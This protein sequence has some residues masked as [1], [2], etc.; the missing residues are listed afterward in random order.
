MADFDFNAYFARRQQ[1]AGIG[2]DSKQVSVAEAMQR[3]LQGLKD[4]QAQV[5]ANTQQIHALK[6]AQANSV[7]GQLGLDRDGVAADAVN[8]AASL[9][10]GASR[11]AGQVV[12]AAPNAIAALQTLGLDQEDLDAY[13]RMQQG[14]ASEQDMARLNTRRR[15]FAGAERPAPLEIIKT[16]EHLRRGTS[17]ISEAF[18][19][20]GIVDP[21]KRAGLTE[22]LDKQAINQAFDRTKAGFQAGDVGEMASGVG[23][24]LGNA[25]KA[26]VNNKGAALEYIVENAPQL[27]AA[28]A[29]PGAM[30]T[31]NAAYALDEFTKGIVRYTN[32]NNGQLPSEQHLREMGVAAVSLAAAEQLGDVATLGLGKAGKLLGRGVKEGSE[33]VVKTAATQGFKDTLK[34]V[35]AGTAKYAGA[36]AGS[37]ANEALTEGY[38]TAVE[39]FLQ[40][41]NPTAGDV[42]EGA[43]I[44]AL[45]GGGTTAVL[46]GAADL[47][48]PSAAKV[49]E[50]KTEDRTQGRVD[51]AIASGDVSTLADSSKPTYAPDRAIAALIEINKK[52]GITPEQ[53]SANQ[54]QAA[55]ILSALQEKVTEVTEHRQSLL[56]EGDTE[57]A[58]RF[59]ALQIKRESQLKAAEEA[60][61]A[62]QTTSLPEMKVEDAVTALEAAPADPADAEAV[63]AQRRAAEA[64][65]TLAM[66][67]NGGLDPQVAKRLA[68]NTGN[69]LTAQQ[70]NY[71]RRFSDA[72]IAE[73]KA[74]GA[75][76]VKSEVLDGSDKNIGI[77]QYRTRI[78]AA[79]A[80]GNKAVVEKNLAM[81]GNFVRDHLGKAQEGQKALEEAKRLDRDVLLLSD[82]KRG[83]SVET[84]STLTKAEVTA[85]GGLAINPIRSKGLIAQIGL[86][87]AALQAA[88]AELKA[89]ADLKFSTG[90][91]QDV[92]NSAQQG[93]GAQ[94][95][96]EAAAVQAGGQAGAGNEPGNPGAVAAAGEPEA[97]QSRGVEST[98]AQDNSTARASGSAVGRSQVQSTQDES[99]SNPST[100]EPTDQRREPPVVDSS[101]V[102]SSPKVAEEVDSPVEEAALAPETPQASLNQSGTLQVNQDKAPEGTGFQSKRFGDFF[103]Q[104][105]GN[106]DKGTVRPLVAVKDFLNALAQDINAALPFLKSDKLSDAQ[107]VVLR[108]FLSVSR[109]WY[110]AI[111]SGLIRSQN[112]EY[113]FKDPMQFLLQTEEG[114]PALELNVYAAIN[115]AAFSW[116]SENATRP[117]LNSNA[118]INKIFGRNE[119]A[120][121]PPSV[122]KQMTRAGSRRNLVLNT[123]GQRA[124][125]ALGIK[126]LQGVPQERLPT[127]SLALGAQVMDLLIAQGYMQQTTFSGAEM[128]EMLTAMK[129][130]K[131]ADLKAEYPFVSLARTASNELPIKT[132]EIWEAN[133]GTQGL[134]DKLF[135]VELDSQPP[136]DKPIPFTIKKLKNSLRSVPKTLA[137]ILAKEN[138]VPYQIR[139][140]MWRLADQM[141]REIMLEI[142]GAEPI[143]GKHEINQSS[144]QAKNDALERELAVFLDYAAGL[145]DPKA[146]IYLPHVP[147][148]QQRVG[149][150]SW[151]NP[152]TSKIHRHLLM[153]PGWETE[154]DLVD[155]EQKDN[156]LLRVA[157]G[158]GIKS[159]KQ[160]NAKTL[161]KLASFFEANPVVGRAVDA[162]EAHLGGATLTTAQAETVRDAVKKAGEKM[163]SLDALMALAE[164]RGAKEGRFKTQ[165]MGEV[166]G[167][168]NGPMLTHL[169]L[170]AAEDSKA[171]LQML[172]RGGFFEQGNAHTQYNQW[173]GDANHDLYEST[174]AALLRQLGVLFKQGSFQK[175]KP[176]YSGKQVHDIFQAVQYFTGSLQDPETSAVTSKGRNIV[177]QPLTAMAFGSAIEKGVGGMFDKFLESVYESIEKVAAET[178][179]ATR[180]AKRVQLIQALNA[181]LQNTRAPKIAE[182]TSMTDLLSRKVL[183]G[184]QVNGM[185]FAFANTIGTAMAQTMESKFAAFLDRRRSVNKAAQGAFGLY[186]AVYSQLRTERIEQLMDEYAQDPTKGIAWSWHDKKTKP[187]RV[188]MHDLTAEQ[189]AELRAQVATIIPVTHTLMS[190]QSGSLDSGI[191]VSKTDRE[192]GSNPAYEATT[193]FTSKDPKRRTRTLKGA[194]LERMEV[195]PGAAMLVMMVH[196]TDSAISH[197][198]WAELEQA[199]NVH[200]AHGTGVGQ[201]TATAKALNKA[202]WSSLLEYSPAREMYE[203]LART[204]VGLATLDREGK[205][206][207]AA[208]KSV[209]QYLASQR[210]E[211]LAD[212][213]NTAW[214]VAQDADRVKFETMAQLAAVDQYALQGG[215]YEVTD[216][217]RQAAEQRLK[218]LPSEQQA[219]VLDALAHLQARMGQ[220]AGAKAS[221]VAP[222]AQDQTRDTPEIPAE[223]NELDPPIEQLPKTGVFALGQ[224]AIAPYGSLVK[225]FAAN[226]VSTMGRVIDGLRKLYAKDKSLPNREF[227]F[228]LLNRLLLLVDKEA[229]VIYVTPSTPKSALVGM[230]ASPARGWYSFSSSAEAIHVLS[231]EF[232]NSGLTP[233]LLTHELTHAALARVIENPSEEAKALLAELEVLRAKAAEYA[234]KNGVEGFSDALGSMQEFVT[235]GMTSLEFQKQVL[236]QISAQSK[237]SKNS[238]VLDGFKKFARLLT[239]VL[240]NGSKTP[241]EVAYNGVTLLVKNVSGLMEAAA[242]EQAK[243]PAATA[244]A[245]TLAMS[246][247]QRTQEM[248]TQDILE[249]LPA[250]NT[251]LGFQ[252][253]LSGLLSGIVNKLHGPA[254]SFKELLRANQATG[255]LDVWLKAKDTGKA[256]FASQVLASPFATSEQE[257]FVLE[258]VEAVVKATLD[259]SEAR[260]KLAYKELSNLYAEVYDKVV[261]R[262]E[263]F[264]DGD[265]AV[266]TPEEKAK[267]QAMYDFVF[268][269]KAGPDG[270]SDYL[271][272][273]AALG[274]AHEGFN[275]VL[276]FATQRDVKRIRDGKTFREKLQLIFEKLLEFFQDKYTKTFNGQ[277]ADRKLEALVDQLVDIEAKH[278]IKL[279]AR[280]AK[281]SDWLD[282]VEGTV[283]KGSDKLR[284][285]VSAAL[286]SHLA[287]N[288]PTNT[289]KAAT[290]AGRMVAGQRVD[291][292]MAHL[293]DLR[294]RT[295]KGRN[296]FV[297]GMLT[298]F[299]GVPE[300]FRNLLIQA[301]SNERE[302]QM[303]V[304]DTIRVVDSAF[305][306]REI[307]KGQKAGVTQAL[308][309]SGAHVLMGRY[310]LADLQNFL[311][312]PASL[313]TAID[314]TEAS[315]AGNPQ[316]VDYFVTQARA[317]GYYKATGRVVSEFL[318]MNG[319]NISRLMGLS[320]KVDE[321]LAAQVEP[322]LDQLIALHAIKYTA[323]KSRAA[324]LVVLNEENQRTDGNGVQFLL[325]LQARLEEEAKAK[326]FRGDRSLMVHGYTSEIFNPHTELVTANEVEGLELLDL[327][328]VKG[329]RVVAD[330][331]DPDAEVR[332]I[333]TLKGAGLPPRVTGIISLVSKT[334]KGSHKHSGFLSPNSMAGLGNT[335]TNL[336]ILAQRQPGLKAMIA[337]GRNFDPTKVRRTFMAPVVNAFGDVTNWRY[338]MSEQTKDDVLERDNDFGRVLGAVAG[339]IY[340]KQTAREQNR[341]AMEAL[342]DDFD[343]HYARMPHQ[344][345][346]VGPD[347]DD[348]VVRET[349][350]VLSDETTRDIKEVWG[351]GQVFVRKEAFYAVFGAQKIS[352]ANQFRK[353]NQERK[354]RAENGLSTKLSDLES[355]NPAQRLFVGVVEG[356]LYYYARLHRQMDH[357]AAERYTQ[358]AAVL[359]MRSERAWQELVREVKDTIVNKTGVVL[360]GNIYSNFSLLM[361]QG[362]PLRDILHHHL[363]AIRGTMAYQADRQELEQLKTLLKTGHTQGQD[364]RIQRE[365]TRLED[366]IARNPVT[367]LVEAGLMPTIVEDVANDDDIY[368]YK[369]QL[370]QKVDDFAAKVPEKV[371]NVGKQVL[372]THDTDLYK[373]LAWATQVSDFVARYTLYQ[374]LTSKVEPVSHEEAVIRSSD[375]FVNYDIP[376]E[377][378]MQYLDDMGFVLFMKYFM[379]IQR[380]LLQTFKEKPARV[381]GM[382][383]LNNLHALGPIVLD[384]AAIAHMGNNPLQLGALKILHTWDELATIQAA[385]AIVK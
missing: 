226:P 47:M 110:P 199:L 316:Q 170:G 274:L 52:D 178:D 35:A 4:Y 151:L 9:A 270:R 81:L 210:G 359:V 203:T 345:M 162:L 200:D 220:A 105:A 123:L 140:E 179:Q 369:S 71:L 327:G 46:R 139:L 194:A 41:K 138:Q 296:G 154:V 248:S 94:A 131:Q 12:T 21:T 227:N 221:A 223:Q 290:A 143:E 209:T 34:A 238:L 289:L 353:A 298:E 181:I 111:R 214:H 375:A 7:V 116:I 294:D 75:S 193:T 53:K 239:D 228:E 90:G 347:S 279:A 350:R 384:S 72:R 14:Q 326:I 82:G 160:D 380:V 174:A 295:F 144:V 383:A 198:A 356:L 246:A 153:R 33:E 93:A 232:A 276:Q 42:V 130:E 190:K 222:Q 152:Q 136:S 124:V 303:T 206:S 272:R 117:S 271:T 235:W 275:R 121:V 185:E 225:F 112:P 260:T 102:A 319:R 142:A 331:H 212:M 79:L 113:D 1:A 201:F 61:K 195:D 231:P 191:T 321:A 202:T 157:E 348:P 329:D 39:G 268:A 367:K 69:A 237:T 29:G 253:Q 257:A 67:G 328:Y 147:W 217:D 78:G 36:V 145:D 164:M 249:A 186:H 313:Q 92:Q 17:A 334:A 169:L 377:P 80:S 306:G 182:S 255:P 135:G 49:E 146:G 297:A 243:R 381:L 101:P 229:P 63:G 293:S 15:D 310:S 230:P 173:H 341:T 19:I 165:L 51:A 215:N 166:D 74:R 385:M 109:Q 125:D 106:S 177:K 115:Y 278:R 187:R 37:A 251:S 58:A 307:S 18:D 62:F 236:S 325:Q 244:G 300:M 204:I 44:G 8:L 252:A 233:E 98:A 370:G 48:A 234:K 224:P 344:F 323:S 28:M 219:A 292:F 161:A 318:L 85:N 346:M 30:T 45:A 245:V 352:A 66:S 273:F 379:R 132:Q 23:T 129:L 265:W 240:F 168:T 149:I 148:K 269:I 163:H 241:R 332:H 114:K 266:A 184:V 87:A 218:A 283:K 88:F 364:A 208:F 3:K 308:L 26:A 196:S 343:E 141:P 360:L 32:D 172:N 13:N 336:Q 127:L 262:P 91:A 354:E 176:I 43:T 68:S 137:K 119:E 373:G 128:A 363:V 65:I 171:L 305:A 167:V 5:A 263:V 150:A 365:I 315:L 376:M 54:E 299:K 337:K 324:A 10:S 330:P 349:W 192:I 188:P 38:Q 213:L 357:A 155:P 216:A 378:Q 156:F 6:E 314:Q 22:D 40:G 333:Y 291:L 312:D 122:R 280:L 24:I 126:A 358:R 304:E 368:S 59:E 355:L 96:P 309:R 366:A 284:Q 97:G 282:S 50:K 108:K 133:R 259:S 120:F 205:L 158:L 250:G 339:S 83:W 338:L 175:K 285:G 57:N 371:R 247:T 95:Q 89:A 277:R 372:M 197:A 189:E 31:T 242:A 84:A 320:Q 103:T 286:N 180:E 335:N 73:N 340:D 317:T 256:P 311:A 104:V 64:V 25:A 60:Y 183:S 267:A 27:L 55:S 351:N 86:E 100:S 374:H 322:V 382:L 56:D 16:S 301:K 258:Q 342:K 254:G 302:R 107:A 207:D 281:Q 134:L 361:L 211:R 264:H 287:R 77:K 2:P 99:P 159:D 76:D 288:L 362:V 118:E 261:D 20:S 11:L 70:R